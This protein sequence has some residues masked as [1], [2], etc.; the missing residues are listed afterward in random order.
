MMDVSLFANLRFTAASGA[1]T[2]A[3]FALGGFAFLM[4]QY[5]QLVQGYS[6]TTTGVRLLPVALSVAAASV[7]GT[8]LALTAGN[9][10]VIATGLFMVAGGYVWISTVG[11]NTSYLE[12]AAQMVIVGGGMGFAT[13]PATESIMGSIAKEK[14]GVGSAVNDAT[15]E[16][17]ATLGVAVLG[18][19]FSSLY[20]RGIDGSGLGSSFPAGTLH[21]ARDSYAAALQIAGA[22]GPNGGPLLTAATGGFMDGLQAACLVA[23]AVTAAAALFVAFVLP[24]RPRAEE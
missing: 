22:S 18:S 23:A 21:V 20:Q 3:F 19:I 13:A 24:S 9:K 7:I 1:V 16:L 2:M 12:I 10:A 8:R 6:P 4:T 5:F 17:G 14:A 15:R 11:T